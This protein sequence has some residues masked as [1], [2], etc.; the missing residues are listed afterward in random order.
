MTLSHYNSEIL[1]VHLSIWLLNVNG[2]AQAQSPNLNSEN[3]DMN[4]DY[5]KFRA[6]CEGEV[7]GERIAKMG[8]WSGIYHQVLVQVEKLLKYRFEAQ[9]YYE[10]IEIPSQEIDGEN[11]H[12][13]SI[14]PILLLPDCTAHH[15]VRCRIYYMKHS[16]RDK[17]YIDIFYA[18]LRA[19]AFC[20]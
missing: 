18:T 8:C 20:S 15:K 17:S 13:Y 12:V 11:Y 7:V 2:F 19:D 1:N 9:N 6:F 3:E 5:G 10:C 4:L 14:T 16:V